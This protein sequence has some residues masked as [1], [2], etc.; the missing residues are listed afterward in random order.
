M[1]WRVPLIL[2]VAIGLGPSTWLRSD[3]VESG[4]L[5]MQVRAVATV[6]PVSDGGPVT[7]EGVWELSSPRRQFY[8]F[9]ALMTLRGG[10]LRAFTD[11]G[12]SLTFSPPGR[13][14]ANPRFARVISTR[15][16]APRTSD[17]ESA[18]RDPRT[19][20]YW[21]GY[22]NHH[23]IGR[24]S[25]ASQVER[26]AVPPQF[27]N[28][29]VNT[30]NEAMARLTD[31]RFIVLPEN[32]DFARVWAGDPLEGAPNFAFPFAPSPGYRPTEIA[33]L[34]DGRVLILMRRIAWANPPFSARLGIADPATI[35]EGEAWE[36]EMLADLD[37]ILPRENY[38]AM[39]V[40]PEQDGSVTIWIMSDD[41]QASLQRTLLAKLRFVPGKAERAPESAKAANPDTKKARQP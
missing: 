17:I 13:A 30:G 18:T 34:P 26:M 36:W 27:A 28:W 3:W 6:L 12:M 37:A 23:A 41:N 35:R 16:F 25:V 10:G 7:R 4:P 33:Q 2:A 38:E 24:F 39:S 21:L 14:P 8:G 1:K 32:D 19:G 9:S 29:P 5:D 40:W 20:T 15:A 31:G 22:E 11:G